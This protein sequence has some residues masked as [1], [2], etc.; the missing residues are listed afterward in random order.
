MLFL[1][2]LDLQRLGEFN[3]SLKVLQYRGREREEVRGNWSTNK[4]VKGEKLLLH[5]SNTNFFSLKKGQE[6]GTTFSKLSFIF[7]LFSTFVPFKAIGKE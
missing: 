2:H 4:K 7:F 5:C 1:L 3:I 6:N